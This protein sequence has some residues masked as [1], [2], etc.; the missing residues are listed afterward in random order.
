MKKFLYLILALVSLATLTLLVGLEIN[1][2]HAFITVP[3]EYLD[4]IDYIVKFG[5]MALLGAWTLIFFMGKGFFRVILFLI[6]AIVIGLG[7]VAFLFPSII[8]NLLG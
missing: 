7:V 2:V 6:T 3:T 5:A 1:S 8:T 4:I